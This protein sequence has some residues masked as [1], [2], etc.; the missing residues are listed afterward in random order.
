LLTAEDVQR[1]IMQA[2]NQANITRA[3]IRLPLSTSTRMV[4]SISDRNGEILGLF[5]MPDATIF[6]IDVATAKSRNVAYYANAD[7]LEQGDQLA[8]VPDG[9]A[10]TN[11][12]FR[13]LSLPKF[14][15][16]I[17]GES[18]PFSILNDPGT[19]PLT[20]LQ[21]GPRLPASVYESGSVQARDAFQPGTNFSR[22]GADVTADEIRKQSGIVFFPGS[23]PLYK[24][25]NGQTVLVGG[26]G[27]SGDGVDQD[28]VVT[29]AG[30]TG[31]DQGQFLRA[32]DVFVDNVR[33]PYQKTN[34]NALGLI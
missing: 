25:I 31:L 8:G 18:G 15:S 32:D 16:A 10:F 19:D 2:I 22:G 12:S 28:D 9:T 17:T 23:V 20:G 6:S 30:G 13:F 4:I 14:P 26:I 7:Q 5:R 24:V 29:A 27:V 11:R 34:R 33:L 21:V 1:Q 3:A